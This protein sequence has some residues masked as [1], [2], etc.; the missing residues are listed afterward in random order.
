[1][2]L[3]FGTAVVTAL[4]STSALAADMAMKAPAAATAPA[5]SWTGFYLGLNGG[6]A[7]GDFHSTLG[8]LQN[9]GSSAS[10]NAA[11]TAAGTTGASP[12]AFTGGGQF[13]YNARLAPQFVGG[14]EIDMDYLGLSTLRQT[15]PIARLPDPAADFNEHA[16]VRSM[17]TLRARAGW[18][19]TPQLL[20]FVTAGLAVADV[21]YAER[22]H[23]AQIPDTSF[24][25]GS[26]S[27]WKTG[28]VVG[29]GLEYA[30]APRWTAKVEYLYTKLGSSNFASAN[31]FDP[32]YTLQH[33]FDADIS[34][35]RLGI[36]YRL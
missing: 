1:M 16:Q 35:A 18:L 23:F 28:P 27:G 22:I 10:G 36:N 26:A 15:G 8:L 19:P 14:V 4:I 30:F 29:G 17:A 5:A 33:G 32:T 24:N 7:W 34:S 20:V 25:Q 31:T 13:G 3:A 6:G 12:S 9:N 21:D 11:L 2:K